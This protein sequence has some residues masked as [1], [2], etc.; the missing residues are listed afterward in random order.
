MR[1]WTAADAAEALKLSEVRNSLVDSYEEV[2][3]LAAHFGFEVRPSM[4]DDPEVWSASPA[5]VVAPWFRRG[6]DEAWCCLRCA[7]PEV[8]APDIQSDWMRRFKSGEYA[9]PRQTI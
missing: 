4:P 5:C 6:P 2:R 7:G 9:S 3:Q 1:H 8:F